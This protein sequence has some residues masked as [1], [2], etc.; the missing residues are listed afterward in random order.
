MI[1]NTIASNL[2]SQV[3]QDGQ[4]FVLFNAIIDSRTDGTHIK[5]GDSFIH[6]SNENKRRRD[7]TKGWEVCIQWKDGSS[8]WN[9]VKD[10][11][12]SFPVKL[13]DYALLNQIADEPAFAWWIK[14]VLNK[15]DRIISKTARKY[16]QKTHKYGL[17]IPHTVKEAIDIDK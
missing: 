13:V 15:R 2:F 16:W 1:A 8:T 12:D 11:K 14:K 6:M 5:E 17:C 10:V 7:T 3:D 9:Q 4:R